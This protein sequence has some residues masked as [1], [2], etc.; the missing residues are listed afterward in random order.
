MFSGRLFPG[1]RNVSASSLCRNKSGPVP[2]K[3]MNMLQILK[4]VLSGRNEFASGGLLLMIIGGVSVWLRAV[5]E[6]LW[7]WI[8]S[9]TTMMITV[10]DDDAAFVWVKEWF[11]EQKFLQRIRRLDLDTTLRNERIA[12]IPAPGKH[13]FWYGGRPFEVWFSRTENTHERSGKRVESLT[14]RTSGRK[15]FFLQQFVD[16]VVKCHLKRQGVQ[17]YLYAY[18]DGWDYVEGYSPRLLESVVLEPGEKEHMLRDMMQFRRSKQRYERLGVP[19]HRGYLLYGPPGTGKTSLVSA[20]AAHFGLS[21]YIVNLADFNDRSL[22]SAV[23]NVPASS[24]LLFED[25]DC[26]TGSQSRIESSSCTGH[27]GDAT[28]GTKEVAR[29]QNGV[30]LSGLLNVLD[31][32]AAPTGVLFV[33]TTNHI[34]KLDPA[35]LRPGRID[36]KL[37]LG[38]A[39]DCQKVELYRRF[40]PESSEAVAWEFVVA[41]GSAETMAE[42]QGMLLAL[43]V[44]SFERREESSD[45]V[46]ALPG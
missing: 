18:N 7:H 22:M 3:K 24:V 40:F 5:P 31:G 36:Y 8:V 14:F 23:N 38:K 2:V 45:R 11:L 29:N 12:M 4:G 28:P 39:S 30:T 32:F 17:S 41:S 33:M 20:L 37:Y 43:E 1:Q 25:I 34:E 13:W 19:Y 35:L 15:R 6:S 10:K 16:D 44:K 9:Q 26:M 46:A 21:I 27:N 42:F